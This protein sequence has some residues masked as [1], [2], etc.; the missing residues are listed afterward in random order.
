SRLPS[1]DAPGG[2]LAPVA[3]PLHVP[4]DH[5]AV[6]SGAQEVCMQRV[7][8]RVLDR[9]P[10]R[11]QSLRHQHAAEDAA[12]SSTR[13][14][15]EAVLPGRLGGP[16]SKARGTG[17][18]PPAWILLPLHPDRLFIAET[19]VSCHCD[20][21]VASVYGSKPKT[22]SVSGVAGATRTPTPTKTMPS[23]IT[24]PLPL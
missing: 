17:E 14:A 9:A 22:P 11:H 8:E 2:E 7:R 4:L 19:D 1:N 13:Q 12:L 23:A 21:G 10:R 5:Q 16:S 3:H 18:A 15:P 6:T 24:G 20:P